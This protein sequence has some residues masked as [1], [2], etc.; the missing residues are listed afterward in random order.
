MNRMLPLIV[1]A[2]V[3][4]A[5]LAMFFLGRASSPEAPVEPQASAPTQIPSGTADSQPDPVPAEDSER[6]IPPQY[7]GRWALDRI[8]CRATG[9]TSRLDIGAEDMTFYESRGRLI[10]ASPLSSGREHRLV[11]G[12]SGEGQYWERTLILRRV[13]H[14]LSMREDDQPD[15]LYL[16]C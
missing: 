10:S 11:L 12:F 6:N 9:E 8:A 15:R 7:Q 2:I 16:R 13:A 14:E 4:A 3:L 5:G 1:A